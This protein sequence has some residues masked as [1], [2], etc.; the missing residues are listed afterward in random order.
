MNYKIINKNNKFIV[1]KGINSISF[2]NEEDAN[3]FVKVSE[4]L[5]ENPGINESKYDY[6]KT[7]KDYAANQLA[8]FFR[9]DVK[10]LNNFK[11][12]G[13]DNIT[14]LTN[15][16]NSTS[17]KGTEMYYKAAIKSAKKSLNISE[18]IN[19]EDL[20]ESDDELNSIPDYIK[21]LMN[22]GTFKF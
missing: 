5:I 17:E 12:D 7:V 15:V 21:S 4:Y 19:E 9:I 6:I 2:D 10:L 3:R 1:T 20:E 11:F 22:L 8:D 14:E 13:T 18:S 16:L